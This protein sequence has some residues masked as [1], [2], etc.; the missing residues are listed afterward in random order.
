M[1]TLREIQNIIIQTTASES[2]PESSS[3]GRTFLMATPFLNQPSD[4]FQ[5]ETRD[6]FSL[7]LLGTKQ[8]KQNLQEFLWV[9]NNW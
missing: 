4:V 8:A 3:L 6:S 1:V 9:S 2:H 7:G 5:P